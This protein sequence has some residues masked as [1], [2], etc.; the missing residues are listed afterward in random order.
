MPFGSWDLAL[1]LVVSAQATAVA[2]VR[3]PRLKALVITFPFPFS[4]AFLAL[5]HRIDATN[6][7]GMLLLLFFFHAVRWL[8][9]ALRVPIVAAIA[10]SALGYCLIGTLVAEVTPPTEAAF[11]VAWATIMPFGVAGLLLHPHRDEPCY[12]SP[13]PLYVKV[14]VIL[15]VVAVLI[16]IKQSLRGFMTMFP[17]V[18]VVAVYEARHSLWTMSRQVPVIILCLGP[19]MLAIHLAQS[20]LADVPALLV[21]WAVFAVVLPVV[22]Y[23]QHARSSL[24]AQ[25]VATRGTP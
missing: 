5:G 8:H 9:L 3:R 1:L 12:R 6:V 2:W 15:A 24:P 17:M 14:P 10:A 18:S 21:G 16:V 4:L 7:L 20:R 23:L 11:W 13:L 25:P 19:M 22:N